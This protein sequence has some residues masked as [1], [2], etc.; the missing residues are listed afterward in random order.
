VSRVEIEELKLRAKRLGIGYT[1]YVRMLINRHVL[2][3]A[4][5]Q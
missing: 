4:P 1:T 2:R 3:E 5:I